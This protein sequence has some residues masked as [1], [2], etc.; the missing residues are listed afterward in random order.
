MGSRNVMF[1]MDLL[2]AAHIRDVRMARS[3]AKT[4]SAPASRA[5]DLG[6]PES[7]ASM[8]TRV[9]EA[10]PTTF[11]KQRRQDRPRDTVFRE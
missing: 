1:P 7:D 4:I 5:E 2:R 6:R 11:D 3:W 9:Q 8:L 10:F